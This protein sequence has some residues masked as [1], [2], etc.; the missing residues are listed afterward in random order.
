MYTY[1][2]VKALRSTSRRR[3]KLKC[4]IFSVLANTENPWKIHTNFFCDN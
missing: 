3:G 1:F 4:A 2:N